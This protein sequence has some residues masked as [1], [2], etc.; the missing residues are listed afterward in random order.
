M[1]WNVANL[2]YT[3]RYVRAVLF[4]GEAL[5]DQPRRARAPWSQAD[6]CAGVDILPQCKWSRTVRKP[7]DTWD[8]PP[9]LT[10]LPL[11][12]DKLAGS[13][14]VLRHKSNFPYVAQQPHKPSHKTLMR[15]TFGPWK[16][17]K[18]YENVNRGKDENDTDLKQNVLQR[19]ERVSRKG[20]DTYLPWRNTWIE[21]NIPFSSVAVAVVRK[22][23][24]VDKPRNHTLIL[25][26]LTCVSGQLPKCKSSIQIDSGVCWNTQNLQ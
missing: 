6:F 7:G 26:P 24:F 14:I 20:S 25:D 16:F 2:Q 8:M 5:A 10:W 23:P 21:R 17:R 13:E 9:Q 15:F 12:R 4:I 3:A 22:F 18:K 11:V 19:K 1:K